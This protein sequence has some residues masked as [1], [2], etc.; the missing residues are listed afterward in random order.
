MVFLIPYRQMLGY[1]LK[2]ALITFFHV[3]FTSPYIISLEDKITYAINISLLSNI[4]TETE[5]RH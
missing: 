2:L 1:I 5:C 3:L 4:Q